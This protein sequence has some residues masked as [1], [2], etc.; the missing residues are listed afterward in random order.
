MKNI[1]L[2]AVSCIS[3]VLI[4]GCLESAKKEKIED[5][6]DFPEFLVGTWRAEGKSGWEFE[7]ESNGTI[8]S[9][10]HAF[11]RIRLKAEDTK[12]IPMKMDGKSI[13]ETGDFLVDYDSVERVFLVEINLSH[14][15]SEI[16]DGVIEG[17]SV[18]VF[19]G[20]VD[21]EELE[22]S[23]NW[24][25]FRKAKSSTPE[26]PDFDMSTDPVYGES[27]NIVF[28]KVKD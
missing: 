3:F 6:K 27:T 11:G 26:N 21:A 18:D 7:L 17:S 20:E 22:W 25:T 23:V 28:K 5:V 2:I 10:V 9:I 15:Y 13:Y 4:S 24:T 16:G 19:T 1:A 8:S 14:F 12:T